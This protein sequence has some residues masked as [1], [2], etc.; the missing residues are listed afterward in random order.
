MRS[1]RNA[2]ESRYRVSQENEN[3]LYASKTFQNRGRVNLF[4]SFGFDVLER[5][6]AQITDSHLEISQ[7]SK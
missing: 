2:F 4:D 5:G 3:T 6:M 7:Q 1:G